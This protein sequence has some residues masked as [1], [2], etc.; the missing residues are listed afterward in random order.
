[1][2][3]RTREAEL[4]K[5]GAL[6]AK[7]TAFLWIKPSSSAGAETWGGE[8]RPLDKIVTIDAEKYALRVED[9]SQVDITFKIM[10]RQVGSAD[11]V[12]FVGNGAPPH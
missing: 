2:E 3:R 12:P 8:L 7:V 10:H 4:V 6:V 1:M 5:D 9:G 11:R